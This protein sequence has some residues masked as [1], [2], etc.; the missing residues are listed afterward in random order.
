M[1]GTYKIDNHWSIVGTVA[2]ADVKSTVTNTTEA[3]DG[4]GME[5]VIRKDRLNFRPVVYTLS[6]GYAF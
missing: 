6:V 2:Y 3:N 5:T 1:G 4:N